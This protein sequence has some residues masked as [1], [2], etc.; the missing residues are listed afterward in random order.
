MR[1]FFCIVNHSIVTCSFCCHFYSKYYTKSEISRIRLML[2]PRPFK[3]CVLDTSRIY[4]RFLIMPFAFL[5]IKL[6]VWLQIQILHFVLTLF[7]FLVF[8]IW[9]L[10]N[11][12]W[13]K[14]LKQLLLLVLDNFFWHHSVTTCFFIYF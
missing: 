4:H 6:L 12:Y 8:G 11:N 1:T 13:S 3:Y 5:S 9:G 2:M 10:I 14:I 7:S